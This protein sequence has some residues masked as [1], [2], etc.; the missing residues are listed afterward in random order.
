[1]AT[2]DFGIAVSLPG[3]SVETAGDQNL[4]FNSSWPIM[5]IDDSLSG[6]IT[7]DANGDSEPII[8]NLGYPPFTLVWSPVNGCLGAASSVN[9]FTLTIDGTFEANN[10]LHYYVF[11]NPLNQNFQAPQ[12]NL[13][14]TP[15]G[16][17][18]QD[19]GIK[20]SK[21]GKDAS[22]TDL[23][24]FTIHSGTRSLMVYATI[25]QPVSA[26]QAGSFAGSYGVEY[27][28]DL[29]YDPVFF[30]FFSIDNFN[31]VPLSAVAQTPP[32]IEFNTI[33]GGVIID[34]GATEEG[35]GAFYIMLDPYITN[36][37]VNVTL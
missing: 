9:N 18:N 11:R 36:N 37:I 24:D 13:S 31:F 30:A 15:Q 16:T 25:Y 17:G 4:Y 22:S 35:W 28:T 34:N 5:K 23:R 14:E 21:D 8:H 3:F 12:I 6:F 33:T 26:L 20:F 29:P 7:I 1:M 2:D 27:D 19:F 32:K 10:T